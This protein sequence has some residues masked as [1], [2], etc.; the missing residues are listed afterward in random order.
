[1]F[2]TK[3]AVSPHDEVFAKKKRKLRAALFEYLIVSDQRREKTGS[4]KGVK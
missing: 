1:M 2:I 3:Y 4:G